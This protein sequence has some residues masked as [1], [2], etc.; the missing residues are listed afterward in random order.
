MHTPERTYMHASYIHTYNLHTYIHTNTHIAT[1]M[2]SHTYIHT[3]TN[4]QCAEDPY[5]E[6]L[7]ER[8]LGAAPTDVGGTR[9]EKPAEQAVI[10]KSKPRLIVDGVCACGC[11]ISAS[12]RASTSKTKRGSEFAAPMFKQCVCLGL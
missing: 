6:L 2:R 3:Y 11:A 9:S 5:Q 10:S 4:I 1:R 12:K 8:R 7:R